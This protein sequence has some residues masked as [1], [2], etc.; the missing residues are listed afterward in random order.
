[1]SFDSSKIASLS[2]NFQKTLFKSLEN[3]WTVQQA[4]ISQFSKQISG[5][6]AQT[7][8]TD[9]QAFHFLGGEGVQITHYSVFSKDSW[10]YLLVGSVMV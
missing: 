7:F 2:W 10:F 3:K 9:I 6:S 5:F 4:N 1:M 8:L